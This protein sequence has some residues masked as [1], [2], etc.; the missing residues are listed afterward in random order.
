MPLGLSVTC[1]LVPVGTWPSCFF[2]VPVRGYNFTLQIRICF[3]C[4]AWS[5]EGTCRA[6]R[7]VLALQNGL[8]RAPY[9]HRMAHF[10][11]LHEDRPAGKC[12]RWNLNSLFLLPK[13]LLFLLLHDAVGLSCPV[14]SSWPRLL[15]P[16]SGLS[17]HSPGGGGEWLAPLGC[18]PE[19]QGLRGSAP[20]TP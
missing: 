1:G 5:A 16:H 4:L 15:G 7:P 10:Q 11:R 20:P 8:C 12:W 14:P 3:L 9:S 2:S 18:S 19:P 17:A 13:L 6:C